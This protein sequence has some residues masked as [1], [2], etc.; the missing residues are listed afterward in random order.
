MFIEEEKEPKK[1]K[2][3]EFIY[4]EIDELICSSFFMNDSE[5]SSEEK[6]FSHKDKSIKTYKNKILKSIDFENGKTEYYDYNG[7]LYKT[8]FNVEKCF[9]KNMIYKKSN[10]W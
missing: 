3:Q 4:E 1:E 8:I 9:T 7:N 2:K 10:N 5:I 6:Y